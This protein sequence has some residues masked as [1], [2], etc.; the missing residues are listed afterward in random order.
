MLKSVAQIP[1]SYVTIST[2][3]LWS[4]LSTIATSTAE[5]S[6]LPFSPSVELTRCL[7]DDYQ[8][9]LRSPLYRRASW[10]SSC[11]SSHFPLQLSI[12]SLFLEPRCYTF[13]HEHFSIPLQWCLQYSKCFCHERIFKV[14]S[15]LYSWNRVL[16]SLSDFCDILTILITVIHLRMSKVSY[17]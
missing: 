10:H 4:P 7:V 14:P 11:V 1:T 12:H 16:S 2:Q 9:C 17:D 3:A 13:N 5:A 15:L 8:P 6:V